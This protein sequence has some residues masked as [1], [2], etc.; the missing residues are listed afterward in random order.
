MSI[1]L[2]AGKWLFLLLMTFAALAPILLLIMNSL[3]S[4]AEFIDNQMGLPRHLTLHNITNAWSSGDYLHAYL[5]SAIVGLATVCVVCAF[6]GL[7]GYALARLEFR[8][9]T[10]VLLW[11]LVSMTVPVSMFLVPLFYAFQHLSLMNTKAGL[12]L[13]YGGIFLPFNV[14]MLRAFFLRIPQQVRR[15]RP[16]RRRLGVADLPAH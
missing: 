12:V 15:E 3:K 5:N 10:S 6:A 4:S 8:G 16:H 9:A 7:A 1:V 13:I 11:L 2:R 14:L